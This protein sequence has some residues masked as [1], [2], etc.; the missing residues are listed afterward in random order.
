MNTNKALCVGVDPEL[1][2]PE[3]GNI[4]PQISQAKL[5]CGLCPIVED[6]LDEALT[7]REEFGIWGGATIEERKSI[8]RDPGMREI[9]LR[10]LKKSAETNVRDKNRV[11]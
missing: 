10:I 9:H 3:S 1:F 4:Q 6:C 8:R 7:N 5:I 2:F 11:K